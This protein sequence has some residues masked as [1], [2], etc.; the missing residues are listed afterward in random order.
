MASEAV[1]VGV[2]V[3]SRYIVG[4]EIVACS[5]EMPTLKKRSIKNS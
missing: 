3:V 1:I 5:T 2:I 4:I